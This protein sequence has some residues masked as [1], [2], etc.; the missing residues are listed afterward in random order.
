MLKK[1]FSNN[2]DKA[3]MSFFDHLEELRWHLVR[4]AF[5]I[6]ALAIV[7]FIYTKEILDYVVFG[8]TRPGFP[9]YQ[10]LCKLGGLLGMGD[11]LCMQPVSFK[12]LNTQ[13]AG[14][15]MLQFKVA[16]IVGVMGA[17]PYIFWEFWQFV[18]PALK[19][20]ELKGSRGII[21]WVSAQFFIG[22]LFS[23][24]LVAPFTINFLAG[25]NVSDQIDNQFLFSDYFGLM[26]QIV[27]GMGVLFELPVLV[28]FLAKLGILGPNFMRTYRRHAIVVLLVLAAV[29]TPPDIL[30]QL[31]VFIPLYLL[32]EI[33]IVISARVYRKREEEEKADE[34]S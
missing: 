15:V 6:I 10:W 27:F 26:S 19:E 5:A 30:D 22:V 23:Y 4:S 12:F 32:Y 18:K 33:S 29:I 24:F 17:L 8:P 14:M 28:Y 7:G 21:F 16:I 13:M 20:R 1:I 9:S 3:E 11:K 25:Y 31:L 34:W 2:E